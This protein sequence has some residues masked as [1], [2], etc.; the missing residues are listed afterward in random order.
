[1]RI[2][3][4]EQQA[5][6]ASLSEGTG[7]PVIVAIDTG[8][9]QQSHLKDDDIEQVEEQPYEPYLIDDENPD[10]I[11]GE[12]EECGPKNEP[13]RVLINITR[14]LHRRD[15]ATQNRNIVHSSRVGGESPLTK[16]CEECAIMRS[17]EG[18]REYTECREE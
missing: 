11:D 4:F 8:I 3:L 15:V 10:G 2:S 9:P 1:M 18:P 7:L 17:N 5:A 12:G 6:Q 16:K 13:E 14:R